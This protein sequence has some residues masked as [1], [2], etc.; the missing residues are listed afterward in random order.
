MRGSN[1]RTWGMFSDGWG[2]NIVVQYSVGPIINLHVRSIARVYMNRLDNQV[3]PIIQTLF[4]NDAVFQ[5][6]NARI[7]TV[8]TVQSWFQEHEGELQHLPWTEHSPDFNIIDSLV[9]FGD[10]SENHIPTSIT[11]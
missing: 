3:L 5:D 7:H 9:S 4:P 2:S 11:S 10:Y 6:A 1:S 8:G